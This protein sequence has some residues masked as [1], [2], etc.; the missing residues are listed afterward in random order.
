MS[1]LI[2]SP[3]L[4]KSEVGRGRISRDNNYLKCECLSYGLSHKYRPTC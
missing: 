2:G 4:A 3:L 1:I